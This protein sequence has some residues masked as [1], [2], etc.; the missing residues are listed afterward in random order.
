MSKTTLDPEM[1]V[2]NMIVALRREVDALKRVAGV[3]AADTRFQRTRTKAGTP[4]DADYNTFTMPPLGAIVIDTTA[5]KI[6]VR[7]AV[8]TWK[9]TAVV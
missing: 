6:W 3:G 8:A 9:S 2:I 4:S 7:T 5:N 1:G